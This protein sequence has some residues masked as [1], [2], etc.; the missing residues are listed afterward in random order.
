V[1]FPETAVISLVTLLDA[2]SIEAIT[3][4]NDGFVGLPVAR[5]RNTRSFAAPGSAT[6]SSM[7]L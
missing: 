4:G 7:L 1:Y 2:G 5:S 6:G 3:I